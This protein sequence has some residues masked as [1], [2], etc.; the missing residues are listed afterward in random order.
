MYIT[1]HKYFYKESGKWWIEMQENHKYLCLCR[2]VYTEMEI[3][4]VWH[5]GEWCYPNTLETFKRYG[6]VVK[7]IKN[8]GFYGYKE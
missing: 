3:E 7:I 1:D 2:I 5:N 4:L 6:K 8:L